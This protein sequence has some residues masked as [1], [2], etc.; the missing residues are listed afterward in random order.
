MKLIAGSIF[1]STSLFMF[2]INGIV[3]N[4]AKYY[5]EFYEYPLLYSV[6]PWIPWLTLIIGLFFIF[7]HIFEK[8]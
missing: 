7:K 8:E 1:I 3:K 5:L 6:V 2:F 4:V